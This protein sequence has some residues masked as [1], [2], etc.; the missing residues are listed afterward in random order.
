MTHPPSST[1]EPE[2]SF[3]GWEPLFAQLSTTRSLTA[4]IQRQ[5]FSSACIFDL[6]TGEPGS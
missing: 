2:G 5:Y 4:S 3:S 6:R 1:A